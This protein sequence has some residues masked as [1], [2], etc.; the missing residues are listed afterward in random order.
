VFCRV[1]PPEGI[2][3]AEMRVS[4]KITMGNGPRKNPDILASKGG[5]IAHNRCPGGVDVN[6]GSF[7]LANREFLM[8]DDSFAQ[9]RRRLGAVFDPFGLR[10]RPFFD[11]RESGKMPL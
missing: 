4:R 5:A 2:G 6:Y 3:G 10:F 7:D 11:G 8:S 9:Q 1:F